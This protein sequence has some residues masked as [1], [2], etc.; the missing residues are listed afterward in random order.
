MHS[1]ASFICLPSLNYSSPYRHKA[2]SNEEIK[3]VK[4]LD[5]LGPVDNK[6]STTA[7]AT[8]TAT[9]TFM[10]SSALYYTSQHRHKADYNEEI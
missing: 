5:G 8:A 9:A 2:N 4:I 3:K 1:T 6:P 7:T 10:Y